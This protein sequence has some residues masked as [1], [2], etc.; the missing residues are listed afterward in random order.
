MKLGLFI[1]QLQDRGSAGLAV[2]LLVLPMTVFLPQILGSVADSNPR[3]LTP[4]TPALVKESRP[5]TEVR[6]GEKVTISTT[7]SN[8]DE[9]NGWAAHFFT[10][11]RDSNG[12]TV[13]LDLQSGIVNA[14]DSVV[15]G[16]A[17]IPE[18]ASMYELRSFA[19]SSEDEL[20]ILSPITRSNVTISAL[21]E[22]KFSVIPDSDPP[23]IL[24]PDLK[25]EKVIDRLNLPTSM[26]FLDR[27]DILVLQKE[28]GRVRL[29]SD[30]VL[31]LGPV[32]DVTVEDQSERG[33]LG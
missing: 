10:E 8:N 6:V 28:N 26:T 15:I 17:W 4:S 11:V 18:H 20:A 7:F 2:T 5:L 30:G 32:L 9:L 19:I 27:D 33:L 14:S 29:I 1:V 12:T 3:I 13:A 21:Q 22:D 25:V 24:D 23:S 16:T 31:K